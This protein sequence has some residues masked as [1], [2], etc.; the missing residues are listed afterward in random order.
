MIEQETSMLLITRDFTNSYS[1]T[2]YKDNQLKLVL[3]E[4]VRKI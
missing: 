2:Q 3:S 1:N 4:L